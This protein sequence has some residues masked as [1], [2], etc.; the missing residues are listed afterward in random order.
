M[1]YRKDK[2]RFFNNGLRVSLSK[3]TRFK[4]FLEKIIRQEGKKTESINYIFCTDNE[5]RKLNKEYLNHDYF[6]DILTFDLST[7]PQK[8][9]AEIFISVPRVTEN[10][11]QLKQSLSKELHRV[12]IHGILHL[13]GYKDK[14]AGQAKQMRALEDMYLQKYNQRFM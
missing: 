13:C 2:I 14:T 9:A 1:S 8:L 5:L 12:M 11:K 7:S 10:A 4:T 3:R 6:T